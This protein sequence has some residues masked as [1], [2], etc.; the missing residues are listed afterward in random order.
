MINTD[1][2]MRYNYVICSGIISEVVEISNVYIRAFN[3]GFG[4][5]KQYYQDQI[6]AIPLTPAVLE[7]CGFVKEYGDE[8]SIEKEDGM[9]LISEFSDGYAMSEPCKKGSG[10]KSLHQIQNLYYIITQKPL[11]ID[12]EK[13]KTAIL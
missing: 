13:L 11:E 12:I 6:R 8:W 1:E 9:F 7:A 5:R 3:D 4:P 2:L 10:I